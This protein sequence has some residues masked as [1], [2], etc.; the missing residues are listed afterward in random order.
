MDDRQIL[1]LSIPLGSD[2][3]NECD[4]DDDLGTDF[5][6]W[7]QEEVD[8]MFPVSPEPREDDPCEEEMVEAE[9]ER[10][11]EPEFVSVPDIDHTFNTTYV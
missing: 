1:E 4:S 7:S 10:L 6:V 5:K 2:D 11:P 8:Q 9:V 3:E